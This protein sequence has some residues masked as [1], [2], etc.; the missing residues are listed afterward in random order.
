LSPF[1]SGKIWFPAS[2]SQS[3]SSRG[4]RIRTP[5][6]KLQESIEQKRSGKEPG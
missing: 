5:S 6:Q 4:M 3:T 2:A 1:D